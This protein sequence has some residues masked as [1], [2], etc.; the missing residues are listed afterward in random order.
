MPLPSL[1]LTWVAPEN[2]WL[3]DDRFLWG[4]ATNSLKPRYL[5]VA[6]DFC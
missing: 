3:E 1:N 4:M 6:G 2:G 5:F